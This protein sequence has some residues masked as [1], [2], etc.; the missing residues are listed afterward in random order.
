MIIAKDSREKSKHGWNLPNCIIQKLDT[1][2]YSLV[3]LENQFTIERKRNTAELA[4]NLIQDRFVRELERMNQMSH[5]YII[6]E[7]NQN[8]LHEYPK[9][10]GI[11]YNRQKYIKLSP[12]YLVKRILDLQN[13][14]PKIAWIFCEDKLEAE[15]K[16]LEIIREVYENYKK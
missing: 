15:I 14:Y 16:A 7:F 13:L 9:N 5:P 10:S 6:C 2:D 3:G 12:A 11:P 8:R 4:A 1:G